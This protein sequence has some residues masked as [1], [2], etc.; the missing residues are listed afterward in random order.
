MQPVRIVL[1]SL[2][3]TLVAVM[4]AASAQAEQLTSYT[5]A[6]RHEVDGSIKLAGSGSAWE[7]PIA[8]IERLPMV[9]L[10]TRTLTDDQEVD[11][12]G[13]L[14]ADLLK[15]VGAAAAE[16]ITVRA[17]DYYSAVIPQSD[18][19]RFPVLL[20]TRVDGRPLSRRDR[21]PAKIIYPIGDHPE[22]AEPPYANRGVWLVSE[23]NW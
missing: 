6:M 10:R 8:E 22:L 5:P 16:R 11:F 7:I 2:L 12:Q 19:I 13:V 9:Q 17:E 1:F 14:L 18:W 23:I 15:H 20:A 4:L 3:S 21:G